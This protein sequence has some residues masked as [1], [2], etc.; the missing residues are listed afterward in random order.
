MPIRA[1]VNAVH[2]GD[3]V[4]GEADGNPIYSIEVRALF[5]TR[6]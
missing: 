5:E 3:M 6:A 1:R 2:E 4:S